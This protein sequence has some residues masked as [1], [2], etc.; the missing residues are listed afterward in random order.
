MINPY[1]ERLLEMVKMKSNEVDI[2]QVQNEAL[3]ID[4]EFKKTMAQ[5]N[6]ELSSKVFESLKVIINE[7]SMVNNIDMVIGNTE[8]VFIKEEHNIT[9]L[10]LETMKVKSLFI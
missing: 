4:G 6:K 5:M 10:I 7:Y 9:N 8:V 2:N 1:K 3:A